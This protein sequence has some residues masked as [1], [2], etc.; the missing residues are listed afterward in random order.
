MRE[1]LVR[2]V[3]QHYWP[4]LQAVGPVMGVCGC[5]TNPG[6]ANTQCFTVLWLS[7]VVCGW[8]LT[9][10]GAA[11]TRCFTFLLITNDQADYIKTKPLAAKT[12]IK[13]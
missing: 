7:M 11:N 10:P 2:K 5:L 8:C 13:K 3:P 1:I 6:A 12:I 9:N 4:P